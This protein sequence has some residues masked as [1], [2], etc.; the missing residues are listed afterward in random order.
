MTPLEFQSPI[1]TQKT[2]NVN[3]FFRKLYS[4]SIPYRYTKN[5]SLGLAMVLGFYEFQSPIGTQKTQARLVLKLITSL[6]FNPL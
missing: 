1:G 5:L 2:I 4:I 6:Y 3:F